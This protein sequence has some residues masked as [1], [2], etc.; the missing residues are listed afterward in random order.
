MS[1][2][3]L[4]FGTGVL[5]HPGG[6][7]LNSA[8]FR[9]LASDFAGLM[10]KGH[11]VVVVSS[12]AIAAGV[13]A[14]GLKARPED[15]SGKQACAAAGQPE[16]MRLYSASFK[17]HG[18]RAAQLL[19]SHGDIDSRQRRTNAQSTLRKLLSVPSMIPIINENDSVAV[20]ELRFG[21]NDRLSAEVALLIDA[22]HL[23][24]CTSADGLQDSTGKRISIVRDIADAFRHVRPEKGSFSV[25]GMQTKLEAVQ[26]AL[27]GGIPATI[28]DGHKP[29]Q[30][31]AAV[32]KRDVGTRFPV[33]KTLS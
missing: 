15:L 10:E 24:I 6:R 8:Q 16:L 4:K 33:S 28:I 27:G 26:L 18:L 11:Q 3:V 21:D 12:A 25:G 23:V 14:L 29:D 32:A 1:L 30:I 31:A 5:A 9:R 20:E 7:A 19:L 13:H 17:K 22:D 2:I